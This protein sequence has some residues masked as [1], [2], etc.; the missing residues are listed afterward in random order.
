VKVAQALLDSVVCALVFWL[1][2]TLIRP[3]LP[4]LVAAWLWA[5][6]PF[7]IWRVAF[8]N[9]ETVL[10][11]LLIAYVC[12]QVIA[13]QKKK[14]WLWLATGL[15]LGVVNLCKPTFLLWPWILLGLLLAA[16][17]SV[18]NWETLVLVTLA[19]VTPWVIRNH[20]LTGEIIP[21]ATQNGGMTAF[22]GNFSPCDGMWETPKRALW[23]AEVAR[24]RREHPNASPMEMERAFYR[25]TWDEVRAHPFKTVGIYVRKLGR[26]WCISSARRELVASLL[27]Q[28]LYLGLALA[29]WWR[30]RPLTFEQRLLP[31]LLLFAMLFHALGVAEIRFCLPVMPFVCVLAAAALCR[32]TATAAAASQRS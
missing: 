15:L 17:R 11:F 2:K 27:I 20:Q 7:A 16:G 24:I 6:Y 32:T 5:V 28:A 14:L 1:A 31:A 12:V 10:T 18:R 21:V 23:E 3:G 19:T 25:A 13:F 26:F 30:M 8:I 29:G 4:A 9:K 22:V